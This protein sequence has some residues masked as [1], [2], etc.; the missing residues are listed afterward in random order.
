MF[1]SRHKEKG[2]NLG[3]SSSQLSE[4]PPRQGMLDL[5]LAEVENPILLEKLRNNFISKRKHS[6][7]LIAE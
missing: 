5:V 1:P 3:A 2:Q 4:D 7:M 6:F